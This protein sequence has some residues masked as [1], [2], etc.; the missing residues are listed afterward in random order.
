MAA[1]AGM[2]GRAA[3]TASAAGRVTGATTARPRRAA[4]RRAPLLARRTVRRRIVALA[5]ARV[6]A[7]PISRVRCAEPLPAA[8][9]RRRPPAR[10][11]LR[12]RRAETTPAR[13]TRASAR[14]GRHTSLPR[15][16]ASARS[17]LRRM[18]E[19]GV[20][21]A[22]RNVRCRAAGEPHGSASRS[23]WNGAA[24]HSGRCELRRR[25]AHNVGASPV[26]KVM[27]RKPSHA[28]RDT[29]VLIGISDV[30][31]GNVH[32]AVD[33]SGGTVESPAPPWVKDFIRRQ[34]TPADVAEAKANAE[35]NST[36]EAEEAD[37]GRRPIV[38]HAEYARVPQP[39]E[40]GSIEPAAIVIRGPAPGIGADP[41]PA[42]IIQ[43]LPLPGLI[44]R[45]TGRDLRLPDVAVIGC[46]DPVPV[47]VQILGA[48][49]SLRNALRA[50]RLREYAVAAVRPGVPGIGCRRGHHLEFGIGG[51]TAGDHQL[52]GAHPLRAAGREDLHVPCPDGEF[53]LAGFGDRNSIS[54][55]F[56]WSH[57]N[58]RSIHLSICAGRP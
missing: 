35:A 7:V 44:R 1:A 42:I 56:R 37:Q 41:G 43:P 54:P 30:Y 10:V 13:G 14:S 24:D 40:T 29:C 52:S 20:A 58:I 53:R 15:Y 31:T 51:G 8:R 6:W 22:S 5:A 46:V 19:R 32:G 38:R 49:N 48:V 55:N 2:T 47:I 57:R 4:G 36:A 33:V 25:W 39:A 34:R 12:A 23:Q 27:H 18:N 17:R 21:A 45:P 9:R 28:V 3:A 16:A 50:A 26:L 11:R